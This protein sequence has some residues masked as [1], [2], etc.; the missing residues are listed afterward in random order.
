MYDNQK[1]KDQ[2]HKTFAT[3]GD[4]LKYFMSKA[5]C[6]TKCMPNFRYVKQYTVK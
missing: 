5:C 6:L 1:E 2:R 4:S 3:T